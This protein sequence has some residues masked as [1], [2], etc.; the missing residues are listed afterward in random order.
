MCV[1]P[2]ALIRDARRAQGLTQAQLARRLGI[3]QPSV[4]RLEAAGEEMSVATLKRALEVLGHSLELRGPKRPVSYDESL[5][6]ANLELT[7]AER[8]ERMSRGRAQFTSLAAAVQR[9]RDGAASDHG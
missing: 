1:H 5:L 9:T 4:A 3:T 2:G 8:L 6:R 7:P